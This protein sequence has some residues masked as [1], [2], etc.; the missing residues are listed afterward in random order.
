MVDRLSDLRSSIPSASDFENYPHLSDVGIPLIDRTTV[1]L[2]IGLNYRILRELIEKRD[3]GEEKLC[4]GRTVLGWFLY[5]NDCYSQS[6]PEENVLCHIVGLDDRSD[7]DLLKLA[8][9]SPANKGQ[10]PT[11]NGTGGSTPDIELDYRAPSVNDDRATAIMDSSCNIIDGH[12]Q[13]ALPWVSNNPGLPNNRPIALSRLS[14][15]GRRLKSNPNTLAKYT[16]KI[17]EMI[18]HGHAALVDPD[19]QQGEG[20]VWY[21]PHLNTKGEKFRIVFDASCYKGVALNE[22]LLQEPNN[23]NLLLGVLLRFRLHEYAVV[24]DIKSMFHQVRVDPSDRS[25][26]RFLYWRDGDP[27]EVVNTYEM[28]VHAFGLTSWPSVARYP[29]GRTVVDNQSKF[30]VETCNTVNMNFYVDDLLKSVA[31]SEGLF[32]LIDELV[33]LLTCGGFK[34]MKFSSNHPELLNGVYCLGTLS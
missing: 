22:R 23:T 2:L 7:A 12:Y 13:I 26:L 1:D 27:D 29:L 6:S 25:A 20:K 17:N 34:L 30:S 11:C 33:K 21:T 16:Q 9:V 3:D 19:V 10:C 8:V 5:G 32:A 18:E 15:L 14:S 4:A 28:S 24:A 31:T